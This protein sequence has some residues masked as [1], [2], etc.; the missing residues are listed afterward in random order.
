LEEEKGGETETL[1]LLFDEL[2]FWSATRSE[3]D[4]CQEYNHCWG[5]EDNPNLPAPYIIENVEELVVTSRDDD[6]C[7]DNGTTELFLRYAS[8]D[9]FYL[10]AGERDTKKLGDQICPEDGYQGPSKRERS[11]RF[12][13]SLQVRG[14]EILRNCHRKDVMGDEGKEELITGETSHADGGFFARHLKSKKMQVYDRTVVKNVGHDHAL[15][16]QSAEDQEG[17]F[18]DPSL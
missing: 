7:D 17:M 13:A 3:R 12:Y 1:S 2:E 16:F 10:L 4:D 9:V 18:S 8:R 5:L 6:S 15:I 11:E 14:E